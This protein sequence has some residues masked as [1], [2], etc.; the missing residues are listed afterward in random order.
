MSPRELPQGQIVPAARP[1]DAFIAPANP[2]AAAP[3][4]PEMMPRVSQMNVISQ[5]NGGNVQG[6]N[7][8]EELAIA[9][10]PFNANLVNLTAN[11]GQLYATN[12]Y[13]KGRNEVVKAQILNNQQ[14]LQSMG[15]Y[16]AENRALSVKDPIA[17]LM[18]DNVNPYRRAGRENQV[19]QVAAREVRTSFLDAYRNLGNPEQ[20]DASSPQLAQARSQAVQ[21]VMDK[22]GLNAGSAGF[23]DYVMPQVNQS[24]DYMVKQHWE[25]RQA[26]LKSTIP[27]TKQAEIL[28]MFADAK[29]AGR[30]EW[31]EYDQATGRPMQMSATPAQGALWSKGLITRASQLLDGVRNEAGL[32]GQNS[33]LQIKTIEGLLAVTQGNADL[34][35]SI[36]AMPF[37][38][39]DA[40]GQRRTVAET[41]APQ[42]L[43]VDIKY[44]QYFRQ[45]K[46]NNQKDGIERY[47]NEIAAAT[48]GLADGP[49]KAAAIA[50]VDAK[51]EY[52][53]LPLIKRLGA[54]K[55]TTSLVEDVTRRSYNAD[56]MDQW[57]QSQRAKY[58]TQW[59]AR[60]SDAEFE[61]ALQSY[62][63]PD[64]RGE[65]RK[66]WGQLR[67]QKEED[68]T[69]YPTSLLNPAIAAAIKADLAEK[70][71]GDVTE[72]AL[73]GMDVTSMMAY[74]KANVAE[75]ARRQNEAYQS[76]VRNRLAEQEGKLGRRL[77]EPEIISTTNKAIREYGKDNKESLDY[78][79]PGVGRTQGVGG[80]A[81]GNAPAET[82]KPIPGR[83]PQ[84]TPRYDAGQLDYVPNREQRLQNWKDE[85][86]MNK[87][88][89]LSEVQSVL[90]GGGLGAAVIRAA[91][92]AKVD[93]ATFVL[94]Q[95]DFY[96]GN[97]GL[98]NDARQEFVRKVKGVQGMQTSFNNTPAP[99]QRDSHIAK[100]G[101][102]LMDVLMG[103]APAAA[104]EGPGGYSYA[105]RTGT[106]RGGGNV[107]FDV[108]ANGN[109]YGGLAKLISSG[110]GGFNSVN[111]GTTGSAGRLNLTSMTIGQVEKLQAARK[112]S[113]VGFAQ[114]MPGNLTKARKAAGLSP[115]AP[116]SGNNQVAMFWA[117]VLKSNKQPALRDY[118][119]GA[120][121]NLNAAHEAL[122]GEWAAVQRPTGRGRYDNDSAGNFASIDYRRVREALIRARQ[123]ITGGRG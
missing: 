76:H 31:T 40:Q 84:A 96:P 64:K 60:E 98:S 93:P 45:Q 107:A 37:G 116:M 110:E 99:G 65:Y 114:W 62:V 36:L 23:Y 69:K 113:A 100:G 61:Q 83:V 13:E 55:E 43:D 8:A 78:L 33:Q 16:A 119:N 41:L 30:I 108:A 67:A 58:G 79:F 48:A 4:R 54:Q 9:L 42:V 72:A 51:P 109:D 95:L 120:S 53:G 71:P 26:Y 19:S 10:R 6:Y 57:I 34:R 3:V 38:P 63:S 47:S 39:P 56:E 89:A 22:Y 46:E 27:G 17:G 86:V 111:Y 7:N 21:R 105:P 102:W 66:Q 11:V 92:D 49:E 52:Q 14:T 73:R 103:T 28:G 122:A 5:G 118:L 2:Q 12:E 90:N 18:M 82:L 85:A 80:P 117:Y 104:A 87:G 20:L 112:V 88:S 1:V 74:G 25:D 77:T 106:G 123:A 15:Q 121:N 44:G 59:N 29:T 97:E 81:A 75:S 35:R 50:A 24:W 68:K 32:P 94:Q 101:A 70:Y 115:D 91:R